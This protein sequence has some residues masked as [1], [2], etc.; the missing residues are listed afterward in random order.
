MTQPKQLR[1]HTGGLTV[2]ARLI[3][4][5]LV[6]ATV[7]GLSLAVTTTGFLSTKA[8]ARTATTAFDA[9]KAE[10]NGYEGWLTQDDQSN[11]ASALSVVLNG[12]NRTLYETTWTQVWAGHAQAVA[13]LQETRRLTTSPQIRTAVTR[14]LSDL[15]AYTV[16]TRE[17]QAAA[18]AGQATHAVQ[19][20]SITN[21]PISNRTQADFDRMGALLAGQVSVV[22]SRVSSTVSSSLKLL[23]LIALISIPLAA[24]VIALIIRSITR[25]LLAVTRSPNGSRIGDLEVTVD[26]VRPPDELARMSW[27]FQ[28]SS[29]HAAHGRSRPLHRSRQP[30]DRARPK[31]DQ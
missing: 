30:V 25:P 9:F 27:A 8:S 17:V 26:R 20:M 31:S 5:A 1:R 24:F 22:R 21:A 4:L 29:A 14:T 15:A 19:L 3:A 16:F 18:D 11:M 6:L 10:R 13:S 2:K 12:S 28:A 7:W 23:A